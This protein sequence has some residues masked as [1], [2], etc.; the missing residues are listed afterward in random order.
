[1]PWN[2]HKLSVI[3]VEVHALHFSNRIDPCSKI[4]HVWGHFVNYITGF[5]VHDQQFWL[6]FLD[7]AQR[8]VNSFVWMNQMGLCNTPRKKWKSSSA[9]TH[10][11][12][13]L[14]SNNLMNGFVPIW[15]LSIII[16]MINISIDCIVSK[17][18]LLLKEWPIC[19]WALNNCWQNNTD[20]LSMIF[21]VLINI[22]KNIWFVLNTMC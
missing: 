22:Q 10:T 14:R 2:L 1:M 17:I 19:M 7:E 16:L 9:Q 4:L 13:L 12:I 18:L 5:H 20:L 3:K 21:F 6:M 15:I 11:D 8:I